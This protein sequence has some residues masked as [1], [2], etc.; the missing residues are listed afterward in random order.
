MKFYSIIVFA[1]LALVSCYSQSKNLDLKQKAINNQDPSKWN[2]EMFEADRSESTEFNGPMPLTAYP[3]E[4][5][6]FNVAS[7]IIKFKIGEHHFTGISFGENVPDAEGNYSP[8]YKANVIFYTGNAYESLPNLVNSRNAPYLTFQGS[9]GN[10]KFLGLYS[11]DGSGYV[12]VN[13]KLFDLRFG[14]TVII[15]Q[16]EN[17]WFYYL[18]TEDKLESADQK[19][20]FIDKIKLNKSVQEM[21]ERL[22]V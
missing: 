6:K 2:M 9:M 1:S 3:V 15:F 13:M 7:S 4:S 12:F 20:S 21:L 17:E 19:D 10:S 11:P 8:N 16:K 14:K 18:Q 22:G 5:Y